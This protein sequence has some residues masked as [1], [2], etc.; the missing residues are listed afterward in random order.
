LRPNR[1]K[2]SRAIRRGLIWLPSVCATLV[3]VFY[4]LASHILYAGTLRPYRVAIPWTWTILREFKMYDGVSS[5]VYTVFDSQGVGR[6]GLTPFWQKPL[7]LSLATFRSD[8]GSIS[9]GDERFEEERR[10]NDASQLS[11]SE[12][13]V[14]DI[15]FVCWQYLAL[16]GGLPPL[17]GNWV[18][19]CASPG[20]GHLHEF[21]AYFNGRKE[22]IPAFFSVLR[23]V[24]R[25]G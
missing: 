6:F 1:A 4:P 5:L 15:R 17:S 20:G 19:Q 16:R 9:F 21:T 18:V 12:F 11:T 14:G 13:M 8:P 2:R 7:L 10:W 25:N 3:L 22:D 24:R 23:R